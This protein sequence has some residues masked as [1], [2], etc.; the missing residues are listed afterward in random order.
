MSTHCSSTQ[1]FIVLYGADNIRPVEYPVPVNLHEQYVGAEH[2][3]ID[4]YYK[5]SI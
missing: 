2:S 4:I 5:F 3:F 1:Y